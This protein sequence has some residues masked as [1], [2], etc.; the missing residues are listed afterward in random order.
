MAASWIYRN[1]FCRSFD[2]GILKWGDEAPSHARTSVGLTLAL[3]WIQIYTRAAT[4][5]ETRRGIDGHGAATFASCRDAAPSGREASIAAVAAVPRFRLAR[6]MPLRVAP[7]TQ[8]HFGWPWRV[9]VA[10]L[11]LA[12]AVLSVTGILI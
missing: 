10:L 11:G 6:P 8:R 9:F 7:G 2:L 1:S 3:R 4:A 12:V 5:K